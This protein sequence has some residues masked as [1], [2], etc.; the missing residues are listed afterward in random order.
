MPKGGARARSGPA[1]DPEALRRERKTDAAGWTHLPAAG[2]PGRAPAWPLPGTPGA[3]VRR[4]WSSEWKRPQ[5][6]EWDRLGLAVEVALYVRNVVRLLDPEAPVNLGTLVRQQQDALGISVPGLRSNRWLI[7]A[8]AEADDAG[9][10][11]SAGAGAASMRARL[12]VVPDA[13]P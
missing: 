1:P 7:A 2:R 5:A 11:A 13:A 10:P 3:D 8:P 12:A 9:K 4:L 6:V